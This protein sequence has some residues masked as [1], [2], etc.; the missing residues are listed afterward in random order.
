MQVVEQRRKA[1]VG[2]SGESPSTAI[3][4]TGSVSISK[5][6]AEAHAVQPEPRRTGSATSSATGNT[7]SGIVA[8]RALTASAALALP[9]ALK[10][11]EDIRIDLINLHLIWMCDIAD[12]DAEGA[13]LAAVVDAVS[14]VQPTKTELVALSTGLGTWYM[15]SDSEGLGVEP[16]DSDSEEHQPRVSLPMQWQCRGPGLP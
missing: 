6:Q 11:A 5:S 9:V 15:D 2:A 12:K 14:L 13:Y 8:P 16:E 10:S 3:S 4:A 1:H 7:A